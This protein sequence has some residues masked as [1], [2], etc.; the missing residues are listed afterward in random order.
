MASTPMFGHLSF[1]A[2]AL[3]TRERAIAGFLA[4]AASLDVAILAQS[5]LLRAQSAWPA[6]P[7]FV[8]ACAIGIW[9]LRLVDPPALL[10]VAHFA[11]PA[12]GR[13]WKISLGLSLLASATSVMLFATQ[14]ALTF[15]WLVFA[16]SVL[17][18]GLAGWLIDGRPHLKVAWR[19]ERPWLIALALCTLIGAV[20]RL[21]DLGS[22]PFGLWFDE[23]YSGL[24]VER[25]LA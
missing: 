22:T 7:L 2:G 23:A 10:S 3:H 13:A 18:I 25:I 24:Q 9:A 20:L 17:L 11:T 1:S 16:L 21:V 14:T 5:N 4:T 19:R 12:R 6:V 8:V 15:A